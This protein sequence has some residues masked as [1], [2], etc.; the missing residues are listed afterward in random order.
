MNHHRSC[1]ACLREKESRVPQTP[2]Q[3]QKAK[4]WCQH[5]CLLVNYLMK[6]VLM[7]TL[8]LAQQV[9]EVDEHEVSQQWRDFQAAKLLLVSRTIPAQQ[10]N[11]RNE[12][13][14]NS[15]FSIFIFN[16]NASEL[17]LLPVSSTKTSQVLRD[18]I[19]RSGLS[20][21]NDSMVQTSITAKSDLG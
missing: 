3:K 1:A 19:S 20:R 21:T 9:H 12:N 4:M 5:N 14:N 17:R 16:C 11:Q 13:N 6:P 15:T 8:I 2:H 18:P 7:K 10:S